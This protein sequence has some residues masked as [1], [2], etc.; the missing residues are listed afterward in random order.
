[1][2]K[3]TIDIVG[4][5]ARLK[6]VLNKTQSILRKFARRVTQIFV[7][8]G[9]VILARKF[10]S[11]AGA[12]KDAYVEQLAAEAKLAAIVKATGAAAGFTVSQLKD[13]ADILQSV[14]GV[15]DAVVIDTLAIIAS[16]RN[17]KSD[18]FKGAAKSS[19]DL[20]A[21]LG[22]DLKS[23]A[24]QVGKALNDPIKGMSALQRVG[25][26]FTQSQKDMVAQLIETNQ[27]AKAQQVI[28]DELNQEFGGTAK[29]VHDATGKYKQYSNRL[30]DVSEKL[31]ALFAPAFKV[32]ETALSLFTRFL[33][34][35]TTRLEKYRDALK[36]IGSIVSNKFKASINAAIDVM[37]VMHELSKQVWDL[38]FLSVQSSLLKAALSVVTFVE[39]SKHLL[40]SVMPAYLI[41]FGMA[42]TN[43]FKGMATLLKDIFINMTIN[44]ANFFIFLQNKLS[45][46]AATFR[47]KG[48][49]D[50]L[51][52]SIGKLPII[53]D[54]QV[55]AVKKVLQASIDATN[56]ELGGKIN[57]SFD[58]GL[59]RSKA[60]KDKFSKDLELPEEPVAGP[61]T[62][63]KLEKKKEPK[64]SLSI[65]SLDGLHSRIL[66]ATSKRRSNQ[67]IVDGLQL[68]AD[69]QAKAPE[70]AA[71]AIAANGK[72]VQMTRDDE[73]IAAL[74]ESKLNPTTFT[75]MLTA[76]N[77]LNT[78]VLAV[79][80]VLALLVEKGHGR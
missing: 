58:K 66:N 50:G 49:E 73:M 6:S 80:A 37:F 2:N 15:S 5:N 52:I 32:A 63:P 51:K 11:L 53:A 20:S 7:G 31:V 30:G 12:I 77:T 76:L 27:G 47:W 13:Y 8:V 71:K 36:A 21:A 78:T 9:L 29:A 24:I 75:E 45:G 46:N 3:V 33:E 68:I 42:F 65:E 1:M 40:T 41:F 79:L 4:D 72:V 59:K 19:L 34:N 54:R 28:L 70:R 26:T 22:Q 44:V 18:I 64:V 14:S 17:I 69:N 74:K 55:S 35:A 60:F 57:E 62:P 38:I 43:V 16:F 25:V 10:F 48:L 67:K 56:A 61:V 39:K 23:S